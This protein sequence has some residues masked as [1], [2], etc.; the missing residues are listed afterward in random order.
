MNP[1]HIA[2]AHDYCDPD[3]VLEDVYL[4]GMHGPS[5]NKLLRALCSIRGSKLDGTPLPAKPY[6]AIDAEIIASRALQEWNG[7]K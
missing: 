5:V 1:A 6:D 2:E 7:E 3:E 4:A